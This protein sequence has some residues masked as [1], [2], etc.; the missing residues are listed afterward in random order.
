VAE[1]AELFF[2]HTYP[3]LESETPILLVLMGSIEND[4]I[5]LRARVVPAMAANVIDR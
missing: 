2:V 1:L 5:F 4:S 3:W